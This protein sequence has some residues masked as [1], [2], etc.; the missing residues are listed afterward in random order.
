VILLDTQVVVWTAIDDP[1]LGSR[2][3]TA[4]AAEADRRASTM[5]AWEIATSAR[6]G[7]LTLEMPAAQWITLALAHLDVRDVSVSREIAWDAGNLPDDV[8]GDPGDRIMIATARMLRCPLLTSDRAIL[9][10]AAAGHL[11]AIDA[12]R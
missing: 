7:R 2:A 8:H 4:I 5:V 1:R 10:C 3:R 12:R 9:R 6:R 11:K